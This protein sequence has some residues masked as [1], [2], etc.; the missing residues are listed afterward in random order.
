MKRQLLSFCYFVI[1]IPSF[2]PS[3]PL[4]SFLTLKSCPD[5]VNGQENRQEMPEVHLPRYKSH[6]KTTNENICTIFLF[7]TKLTLWLPLCQTI[8]ILIFQEGILIVEVMTQSA[9]C[10]I[11]FAFI[12]F[13]FCIMLNQVCLF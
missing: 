10:L 12:L 2:L 5:A 1:F 4:S 6:S 13:L 3:L 9:L 11:L 7:L 8:N